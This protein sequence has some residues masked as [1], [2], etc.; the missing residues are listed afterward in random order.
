M[1]PN[2]SFPFLPQTLMFLLECLADISETL[3]RSISMERHTCIKII[4]IWLENS[5]ITPCGSACNEDISGQPA[6]SLNFTLLTWIGQAGLSFN[7]RGYL[8]ISIHRLTHLGNCLV[9]YLPVIRLQQLTPGW[10]FPAC[11]L[12]RATDQECS[13]MTCLFFH[14]PNAAFT[15]CVNCNPNSCNANDGPA[16]TYFVTSHTLLPCYLVSSMTWPELPFL[17]VEQFNALAF[18]WYN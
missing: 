6:N 9:P 2:S 16:P 7:I 10:S 14:H 1:T 18:R 4:L 17:K 15:Q 12:I 8:A 3:S 13:C 5:Q 11:H